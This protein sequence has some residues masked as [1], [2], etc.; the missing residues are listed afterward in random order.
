MQNNSIYK[1]IEIAKN[2]A[3]IPVLINGKTIESRYNPQTEAQRI[4]ETI[5][6]DSLFFIVI[7]IGGGFLIEEIA[8]HNPDSLIIG[9]EKTK[10]DIE[11]IRK[12]QLNK[13]LEQKE[14]IF[15]TDSDSLIN[16]LIQ[17]YV[18]VFYGNLEIIEQRA[19]ALEN[20]ESKNIINLEIK[21]ALQT[22]SQD[23][24]VQAHF[25][26]IWQ[27]NI[28]NN[29]QLVQKFIFPSEKIKSINTNL[30]AIIIAA[31]PSVDKQIELLKQN[32]DE[33]YIIATDTAYSILLK[34][35]ICPNAVISID[36]QT[37]SYNHFITSTNINNTLFIFDLCANPSAVKYI[38][39]KN[40]PILFSYNNHPLSKLISKKF[41]NLINLYTGSGTVTI[42]ALDF[43]LQLGFKNIEILGADFSYQN[44][45][46]Y[47]KSTYLDNL[48]LSSENRTQSYEKKFTSLMMRTP[49]QK[50]NKNKYTTQIL[51][52]Y[53]NSLEDYLKIKNA[54]FIKQNDVYQ[55]S[56][57]QT[58][59]N[60][61]KLKNNQKQ[62]YSFDEFLKDFVKNIDINIEKKDILDLNEYEISLFPLMSW[63][64]TNE[65]KSKD[66]KFIELLNLA[67]KSLQRYN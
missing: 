36:G 12:I 50:I 55:I 37:V 33:Y 28:L 8:K 25:G 62:E 14:T 6:T 63:I 40:G 2:G 17:K 65:N 29:L 66:L 19:W 58:E 51:Q 46:P 20:Q 47:A 61:L 7:G 3:Q 11:F 59:N 34:N 38:Y 5:S 32:K 48:Y 23:Y 22:I 35:E 13:E 42:A 10:E 57:E 24:S 67:Y 44:G 1:S 21:K 18:P 4:A 52:S 27:N 60:I 49:L 39:E 56:N 64:K 41:N 15:F 31:G 9:V 45:K 30:K 43:A 16:L 26:K 53:E 54:K